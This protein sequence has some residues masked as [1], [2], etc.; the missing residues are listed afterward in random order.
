MAKEYAEVDLH[1]VVGPMDDRL[2]DMRL[3]P[4]YFASFDDRK[5]DRGGQGCLQELGAPVPNMA[6]KFEKF[7]ALPN[8]IFTFLYNINI[9][10]YQILMLKGKCCA[11]III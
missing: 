6:L 4:R 9:L 5:K 3:T 7:T 11:E 1:G 10:K 8:Y 2:Y